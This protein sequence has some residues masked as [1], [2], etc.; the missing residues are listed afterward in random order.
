V[1]KGAF[2]GNHFGA[3]DK[4]ITL[5]TGLFPA[6]ELCVES[7]IIGLMDQ[8]SAHFNDQYNEWQDLYTQATARVSTAQKSRF[9]L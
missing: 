1:A 6:R 8:Q 2:Q 9:G 5:I 7:V 4:L 3:L